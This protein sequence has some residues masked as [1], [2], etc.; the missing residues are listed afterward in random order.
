MRMWMVNPKIM[1]RL[2]LLGEH[3]E[4]HMFVGAINRGYSVKGYLTKGLLE[5]Q[6]LYKRHEELVKEMKRRG[7][8]H[9]SE[10]DE[11]WKHAERLG[12]VDKE[13]NLRQLIDRCSSCRQRYSA[14]EKQHW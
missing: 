1:C 4:I 13:K 11:I 9:R 12:V 14:R 8:K 7:Y 5:I 10:I 2:H 3:A 6:S